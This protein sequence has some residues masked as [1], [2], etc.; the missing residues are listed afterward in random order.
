MIG[1]LVHLAILLAC[2]VIKARLGGIAPGTMGGIGLAIFVFAFV[3]PPGSSPVT[4]QGMILTEGSEDVQIFVSPENRLTGTSRYGVNRCFR[5]PYHTRT[6]KSRNPAEG[7]DPLPGVDVI[8]IKADVSP[9]LPDRAAVHG[10]G[11]I[12]AA[13][14]GNGNIPGP[15]MEAARRAVPKG[16]AVVRFSGVPSG[17][18]GRNLDINGDVPGTAARGNLNPAKARVLLKPALLKT[19]DAK[20]P[21]LLRPLLFFDITTTKYK[22]NY[23]HAIPDI[24]PKRTYLRCVAGVHFPGPVGGPGIEPVG[25]PDYRGAGAGL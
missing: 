2:I 17:E 10:A 16:I 24:H 9:D 22:G 4:V 18:D 15:A 5:F 8:Y 7:V 21:G 3:M 25:S 13:G 23:Y 14:V 6:S 11:R 12:F 20:K 1:L 19:I